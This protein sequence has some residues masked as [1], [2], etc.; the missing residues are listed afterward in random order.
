[1]KG[2]QKQ[3][4]AKL[5]YTVENLSQVEIAEKTGVSKVTINKWVKK[6]KWEEQK[7][8]LTITREQQLQRLYLQISELNKIIA[9]REQKYPTSGEADTLIKLTTAINKMETET[10]LSDIIGVSKKF[11]D[12]IRPNNLEKAKELSALFDAFIKDNLK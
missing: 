1:M 11:L 7:V 10:S 12:W 4:W 9:E 5:L 2:N 3:D 8:S 6:F